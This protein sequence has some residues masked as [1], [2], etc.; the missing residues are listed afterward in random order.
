MGTTSTSAR[1]GRC[2]WPAT[3]LPF[4]VPKRHCFIFS[5][6]RRIIYY[7]LQYADTVVSQGTCG[8]ARTWKPFPG[9]EL[10]YRL[11]AH[12]GLPRQTGIGGKHSSGCAIHLSNAA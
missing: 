9:T 11:D 6:G 3:R 12:P 5:C 10:F 4:G 1:H 7:V 8:A 2:K